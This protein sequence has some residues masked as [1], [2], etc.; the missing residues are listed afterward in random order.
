MSKRK[1]EWH[2]DA[3]KIKVVTAYLVLG[4][5][6][7][8]EATTGVPAGTVR[9]WKMEPWWGELVQQI[10]SEDT[11]ELDAK[12]S[13]VLTKTLAV[14][15]DR[16]ERGDFVFNPRTGEW[17]RRPVSM[18]DTWK[19]T[20]E[21]VDLRE[22]LRRKPRDVANQEAVTD[23]L[24]NLASE[25]ATMAKRRLSEKVIE[26]EVV[27]AEFTGLCEGLQAGSSN[28]VK[29]TSYVPAVAEPSA[30]PA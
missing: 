9:R 17:D 15:D 4:K 2:S 12:L 3:D 30:V 18:K 24:K 23:I 13:T 1:G 26:G 14:L 16:L 6:P 25:F 22:F 19:V 11:Q 5:A 21:A 8:V 20:K 27:D 10:Q 29:A 28:G 7:L